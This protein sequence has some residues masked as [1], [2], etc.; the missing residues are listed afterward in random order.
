MQNKKDTYSK[1][2]KDY[3]TV[4]LQDIEGLNIYKRLDKKYVMPIQKLGPLLL[5]LKDHYQVLEIKGVR[6]SPYLTR[7]FDTPGYDFYLNHHNQRFNRHKVRVRT[8]LLNDQ[9]FLEVK[10]KTNKGITRK[11]RI[12]AEPKNTLNTTDYEYL[13]SII[14]LH[15]RNLV[16]SASNTFNRI[17]LVSFVTKERITIDFNLSFFTGNKT[18]NLNHISIVEVKREKSNNFSPVVDLLKSFRVYP[19]GFSKY[20]MSIAL[21]NT[22]LKQNS[23]KKNLLFLKKIESINY[24]S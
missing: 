12:E 2:L 4:S 6:I 7:Y 17:T 21:H 8:Y 16:H 14:P 10:Q 24:A 15:T 11:S 9:T 18:T 20:C 23:F 19:R 22:L 13:E 1:I 3:S 5:N